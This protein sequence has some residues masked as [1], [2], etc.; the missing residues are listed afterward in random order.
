MG[1]ERAGQMTG[2]TTDQLTDQMTGRVARPTTRHMRGKSA[3][4]SSTIDTATVGHRGT[5]N[6]AIQS[7]A[8]ALMLGAA[9][10]ANGA[11]AAENDLE[12]D[13]TIARPAPP[14][15]AAP[16]TRAAP[17]AAA[18]P[19]AAP[20]PAPAAPP[21]SAEQPRTAA[22]LEK[23]EARLRDAQ[24]RLSRAASEVAALSSERAAEAMERFSHFEDLS[25]RRGIIG[26]QLSPDSKDGAKVV[27]V[28]PGGPAEQAGIR[29]GDIIVFVNGKDVTLDSALGD[30]S[31]QVMRLLRTA[32]PDSKVKVRVMR[33]GKTKDFDVVVR[34]FAGAYVN[35]DP[36]PGP[37]GNAFGGPFG[38]FN[39]NFGFDRND[40]LSGLEVTTLTPQLGH[41]FGTDKGVLVVRAPKGEVYK[42][43]D[44]DVIVSIDGREPTSG[45][46]IT[47]I[48]GSYQPG[49]KLTIRVM[50]DRKA[51]DIV[52]TVP[53]RARGSN[54]RAS[55]LGEPM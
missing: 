5:R 29:A 11:H 25:P 54:V 31:R 21:K 36:P 12:R 30:P 10:A 53:E 9:L 40:A 15:P 6:G 48:L 1:P 26:V 3:V 17:A 13:D 39:F 8:V 32:Q 45:S 49:E 42:L 46:H 20:A 27:D 41:Y 47:R 2:Q 7:G 19:R 4:T 33:D 38:P 23:L 52:V 28:S 22:E 14:A 16:P 24:E 55:W 44:G 35:I 51:Q 43:Q 34:P 18:T 50:R 37:D